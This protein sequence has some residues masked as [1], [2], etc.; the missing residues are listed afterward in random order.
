MLDAEA[1]A[2]TLVVTTVLDGLE[3]PYVIGGSVASMVHGMIRSTMDV[4]IVAA[5][6]PEHVG[7]FLASLSSA[8]YVD[9]PTMR[10]AIEERGSFNLIHLKTMV[11]VDVFVPQ[12]RPFDQQ[13]LTRRI[14]ERIS[15]DVAGT[16][17]ILTAEDTILAKLDWF[18]LGEEV[19]ERQWRD[20]L[21]VLKTQ[22]ETLDVAYLR[23]W[24]AEL[25]VADLLERALAEA[26]K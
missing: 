24:A 15:P 5:L 11:K 4:D 21:G 22:Q 10:Q 12:N 3:V 13:Q 1:F 26:G 18:R 14:A 16:L 6:R 7:P 19:S 2:A 23:Q 25:D 17:W 20:I 8:F 9:E